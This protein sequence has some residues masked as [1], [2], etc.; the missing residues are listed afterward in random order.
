MAITGKDTTSQVDKH[1]KRSQHWSHYEK[2]KM[3]IM[4]QLERCTERKV[5][6]SE[7]ILDCLPSWYGK[8]AAH[9]LMHSVKDQ[10][11]EKQDDAS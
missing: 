1:Q 7:K 4:F 9:V 11:V 8:L 3:N 10:F 5:V 2:R 6:E